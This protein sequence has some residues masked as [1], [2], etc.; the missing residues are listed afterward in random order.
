MKLISCCMSLNG[1]QYP[2]L[3]LPL[4]HLITLLTICT[5]EIIS[6]G[7]GLFV[8]YEAI[9]DHFVGTPFKCVI[10]MLDD[11][12]YMSIVTQ[13][14]SELTEVGTN[15]ALQLIRSFRI[16][17]I[18]ASLL[19]ILHNTLQQWKVVSILEIQMISYQ[20][21]RIDHSFHTFW[22][23]HLF[24]QTNLM[25]NNWNDLSPRTFFLKRHK[26]GDEL[27]VIQRTN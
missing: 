9:F 11:Q 6:V 19:I 13:K 21:Y 5:D 23:E 16:H 12:F 27:T 25:W 3:D 17:R 2:I 22:S 20:H 14:H 1:V 7:D 8:F 4:H 10:E 26:V 24:R 15:I 18:I